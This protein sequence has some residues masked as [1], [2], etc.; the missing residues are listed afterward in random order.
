M[1]NMK[2]TM[3]FVASLVAVILISMSMASANPVYNWFET[4]KNKTIE[5]QKKNWADGKKQLAQ[6]KQS[7]LNLFKKVTSNDSQN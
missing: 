1:W 6:T 3:L 2:N 7:I 4:E 5:F